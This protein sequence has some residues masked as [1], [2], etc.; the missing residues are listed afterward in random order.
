MRHPDYINLSNSSKALLLDLAFQFNGRN[1]GDLTVAFTVLSKRGWRSK[2][3]L[4]KAVHG[5]LDRDLI[6]KT[7]DGR[8]QNPGSCP[9]LY[10]LTW[11][12]V[13]ECPGKSLDIGPTNVPL[14]RFSGAIIEPPGP[15]IGRSSDQKLGP[16]R[17]RDSQGRYAS[18]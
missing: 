13:D 3:T 17:K 9:A 11:L 15:E 7:K 6:R 5:L 18:S 4:K 14:R 16:N 12:P 10:A 1:N 2:E 8:F